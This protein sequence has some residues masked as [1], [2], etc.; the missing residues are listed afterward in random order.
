MSPCPEL[1]SGWFQESQARFF[2]VLSGDADS[3]T[4]SGEFSIT[5]AV[6]AGSSTLIKLQCYCDFNS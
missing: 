1:V 5:P 6:N 3:E 4:G 2:Y